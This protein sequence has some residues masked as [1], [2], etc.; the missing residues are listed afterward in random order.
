MSFDSSQI[1]QD[2]AKLRPT[3]LDEALLA[4][5]EASASD[6][7]TRLDP[8]EIRFEEDMRSNKPAALPAKLMASLENIVGTTAFPQDVN[9]VQFP[10]ASV[11]ASHSTFQLRAVAAA[12]AICGALTALLMPVKFN[13]GPVAKTNPAPFIA[14]PN[15]NSQSLIPAG[16]NRELSEAH[17]EGF[18]WRSNKEAQHVLRVVYKERMTLKDPDGKTYQIEQPRVEY[19]LLPEKSD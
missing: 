1:E 3:V 14:S 7:L 17:D 6:S 11:A 16:F 8:E 15:L 10:Q 2:L 5:L 13:H 9:I 4:R 12:V 18:V 19:I